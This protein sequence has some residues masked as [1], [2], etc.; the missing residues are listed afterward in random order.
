MAFEAT[1]ENVALRNAV[2]ALEASEADGNDER[3]AVEASAAIEIYARISGKGGDDA[4]QLTLATLL[5][6]HNIQGIAILWMDVNCALSNT[7][8]DRYHQV[9]EPGRQEAVARESEAMHAYE[10]Y[11]TDFGIDAAVARQRMQSMHKHHCPVCGNG[12]F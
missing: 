7:Y 1:P 8:N 6:L 2:L 3:L 11:A 4:H 10:T 12:Y 5:E 9:N